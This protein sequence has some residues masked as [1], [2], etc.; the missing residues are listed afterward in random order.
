MFFL[1]NSND[2]ILESNYNFAREI[3]KTISNLHYLIKP[4]YVV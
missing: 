4:I 2:Y 3:V 1:N